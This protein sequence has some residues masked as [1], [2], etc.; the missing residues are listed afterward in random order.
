MKTLIT[1]LYFIP[2]LSV[3]IYC[4]ISIYKDAKTVYSNREIIKGITWALLYFLFLSFA[5]TMAF[6]GLLLILK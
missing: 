6:K 1:L 3:I 5:L 2:L 4:I